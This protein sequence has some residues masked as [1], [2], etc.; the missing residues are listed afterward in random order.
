MLLSTFE[1]EDGSV[2][3]EISE[4]INALAISYSKLNRLK[5]IC[6]YHQIYSG[7][8]NDFDIDQFTITPFGVK[9]LEFIDCDDV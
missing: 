4:G 6:A 7:M 1:N 3:P 8:N 2:T 9:I 5:I